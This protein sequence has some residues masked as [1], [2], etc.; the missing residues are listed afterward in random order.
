MIIEND[1]NDEDDDDDRKNEDSFVK[2]TKNIFKNKDN[3]YFRN[4][5]GISLSK[6]KRNK[7][8]KYILKK[9]KSEENVSSST[10]SNKKG[11][12]NLY[13]KKHVKKEVFNMMKI[14]SNI[15]SQ[16][17]VNDYKNKSKNN[18]TLKSYSM[19]KDINNSET[20][21]TN[22]L[23]NSV[24][25]NSPYIKKKPKINHSDKTYTSNFYIKNI[26]N[27]NFIQNN[28]YMTNNSYYKR[29]NPYYSK[30]KNDS[31]IYSFSSN[32]NSEKEKE[33]FKTK[34]KI[35]FSSNK[36]SE[37]EKEFFKTKEKIVY[38]KKLKRILLFNGIN[39]S[40]EKK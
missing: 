34:E 6:I 30:F 35:V 31:K 1:N 25:F 22:S 13:K 37:K 8:K 19:L 39:N 15:M 27:T 26:N 38:K 32:K 7:Y 23:L 9:E 14:K 40:T 5:N 2:T 3:N 20:N 17:F 36:N 24:S 10:S 16:H 11:N 21:K 33:F 29:P 12:F 28:F 18:N 4:F